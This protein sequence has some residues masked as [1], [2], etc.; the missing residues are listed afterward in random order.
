VPVIR[1]RPVVCLQHSFKSY[2][3][4]GDC[5]GDA[6]LNTSS[7]VQWDF[8]KYTATN[9]TWPSAVAG[10]PKNIMPHRLRAKR[11]RKQEAS[12][13]SSSTARIKKSCLN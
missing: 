4:V 1:K 11:S 6:A 13:G 10:L 3:S 12:E 8:L 5:L 7:T 2:A 9:Q